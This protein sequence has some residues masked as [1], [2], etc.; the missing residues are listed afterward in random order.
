MSLED[1]AA[2]AVAYLAWFPAGL[3]PKVLALKLLLFMFCLFSV[4][5]CFVLVQTFQSP[6]D[7]P[8]PLH[9]LLPLAG[10]LPP[11]LLGRGQ[12]RQHGVRRQEVEEAQAAP[13]VVP[14]DVA[15][16]RGV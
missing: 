13:E 5:N 4:N 1:K 15:G 7:D 2:S 8:L 11:G 9:L 10:G 14:D 12:R 6:P 16:G 3:A